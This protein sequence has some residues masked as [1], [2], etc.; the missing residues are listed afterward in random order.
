MNIIKMLS[1]CFLLVSTSFPA[2]D[3]LP[4]PASVKLPFK[5]TAREQID[6]TQR[7]GSPVRIKAVRKINVLA[8]D[9]HKSKNNIVAIYI[10]LPVVDAG[11]D[12]IVIEDVQSKM[13]D[14]V[15]MI[16]STHGDS[17]LV[18]YFN[19]EPG[20][21]DEISIT[22]TVDIYE[23]RA[24]ISGAKPY[25]KQDPLYQKYTQDRTYAGIIPLDGKPNPILRKHLNK[26]GVHSDSDPVDKALKIYEYL[27]DQLSYAGFGDTDSKTPDIIRNKRAHCGQYAFAFV[28][29]CREAA[30]PA[31]RCAGFAFS[32][33]PENEKHIIASGH[34]WAE[35]FVEGLGWIPVDP[36]MGDKR[37][38]R[39]QYY[40]GAVDNAR[41]CVSKE[42]GH[43]LLP[44][45]YKTSAQAELTF[46]RDASDF[47]PFKYPNTI[48]GVHRFQYRFD[49]PIQISVPDPY[50]PS[51]TIVSIQ[52]NL[53]KP[54]P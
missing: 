30:V 52:G 21:S 25:N 10:G 29:L 36:T 7:L 47:K 20:F 37:D 48:Q 31:R 32:N 26:A 39:K 35:F 13:A 27:C 43:D 19:A 11:Q 49:R 9:K 50:G 46:T 40:F 22:F 16:F 3:E 2:Q 54:N 23:H 5:P 34:N 15:N 45:W 17:L 44:L 24:N 33:D 41:L 51:L 6:Y 1:L 28:Q 14:P 8:G 38:S 4:I 12:N 53:K 18:E 42:G